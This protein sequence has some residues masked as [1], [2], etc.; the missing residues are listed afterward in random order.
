MSLVKFKSLFL[1]SLFNWELR[2]Y[3]PPIDQFLGMLDIFGILRGV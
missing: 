2:E 3:K 1:S